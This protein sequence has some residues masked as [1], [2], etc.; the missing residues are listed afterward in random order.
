MFDVNLL[1]RRAFAL[2]ISAG[3][4]AAAGSAAYAADK[5]HSDPSASQQR[6]EIRKTKSGETEYCAKL[7]P[8]IG[9]RLSRKVCKTADEWEKAGVHINAE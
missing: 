1:A 4:I 7:P 5:N 8:I 3:M 2:S 9:T 6:F